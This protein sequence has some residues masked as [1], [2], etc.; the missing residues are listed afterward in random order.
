MMK[1]LLKS[2]VAELLG[3]SMR[4]VDRLRASGQLPAVR[5]RGSPRFLP[6]DVAAYVQANK[7]G[8]RR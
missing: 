5:V 6:A 7:E 1:L 2:E 3:V 4:T 8:G